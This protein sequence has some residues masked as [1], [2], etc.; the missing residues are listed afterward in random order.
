MELRHLRYFKVVAETLN[1]TRAAEILHIAQPPLSRQISQLEDELG[2]PLVIRERPIRL[3]EA[4]SF[5]YKQICTQLHQLEAI[6]D[7]TRHIG[8]SQKYCLGIGFAPSTLYTSL[9]LLIRE[10]RQD[11][12]LELIL[13]EMTTLQQVEALKNGRIDIGLGRIRIDDP[14]IEQEVLSQDPMVAVLPKGHALAGQPVTLEQLGNEEFVLYPAQPRPSYADHVLGLFAHHG[15][16]LNVSQW[17]NELQTALGLVAAGMGITLV[18]ASVQQQHRT[19]IEYVR[20]H[21]TRAC[22]PIIFSRRAG[23]VSNLTSKCRKFLAST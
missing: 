21:D 19:D 3:T 7:S 20:L 2:T 12:S 11:R 5:F 16:S 17:A 14:A 10:L 22:S 13:S 1:F 8:Q 4:G 23:D 15:M 18:P 6:I 9:P